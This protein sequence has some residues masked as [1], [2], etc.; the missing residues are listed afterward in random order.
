VRLLAPIAA[1][2]ATGA[3]VAAPAGAGGGPGHLLVTGDE[4]DETHLS[5]LL[6]RPK[7][8]PGRTEI[9]FRNAGEDD[10]DLNI[11]R[12]GSENETAIGVLH[13][14]EISS[15]ELRL[16]RGAEYKLWCSLQEG[17]H[18][19]YGMEAKRRVRQRKS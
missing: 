7:V 3:L 16:R 15:V 9:E 18:R 14:D 12:V 19:E 2:L 17:L 4:I 1:A 10:H 6:S 11:K 5:L 13:H 8:D